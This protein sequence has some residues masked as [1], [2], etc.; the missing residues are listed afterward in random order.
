MPPPLNVLVDLPY[1]IIDT[2]D[3][4][5]AVISTRTIQSGELIA[6]D[7]PLLISTDPILYTLNHH[8]DVACPFSNPDKLEQVFRLAVQKMFRRDEGSAIQYA[9]LRN[10]QSSD[11]LLAGRFMT[12]AIQIPLGMTW[13]SSLCTVLLIVILSS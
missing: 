11:L 6:R 1:Q 12:N 10:S 4:G 3:L 2:A 13:F 8:E 7:S 5:E 9:R